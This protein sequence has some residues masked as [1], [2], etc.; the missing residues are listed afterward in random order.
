M[1]A[2]FLKLTQHPV[3]PEQYAT[4][5][6]DLP[7]PLRTQM[8]DWLASLTMPTPAE[9]QRHPTALTGLVS[10]SQGLEDWVSDEIDW[11]LLTTQ[12]HHPVICEWAL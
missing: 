5:V 2:M 9:I 4:G 7:A 11:A 12:T 6:V 8:A 10:R 1:A 3:T